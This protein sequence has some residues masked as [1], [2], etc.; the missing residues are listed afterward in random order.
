M[1]PASNVT[2]V[3][4]DGD[5]LVLTI[6]LDAQRPIMES[7]VP[8]RAVFSLMPAG[9][10]R[11]YGPDARRER[12]GQARYWQ[13]AVIVFGVGVTIN[14]ADDFVISVD[15]WAGS[16]GL[17]G[18]DSARPWIESPCAVTRGLGASMTQVV[19]FV[20]LAVKHLTRA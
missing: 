9:D 8:L 3:H 1:F 19:S 6:S 4:R 2:G 12:D 17:P 14:H 13:E 11:E 15:G 16:H 5:M 20:S 7:G 18:S 10:G